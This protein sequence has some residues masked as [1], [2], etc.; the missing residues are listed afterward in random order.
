MKSLSVYTDSQLV[1]MHIEGSYETLEWSMV[2]YLKKVRDLMGK[3]VNCQVQQ[4]PCEE[5]IRADGISDRR[6][7][8]I[9]KEVPII[10][11]LQVNE[12][13]MVCQIEQE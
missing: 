9:V 4:I 5:N 10:D 6:I 3:F 12:K 8:F 1:A 13:A 2:Q 11:E 7:S